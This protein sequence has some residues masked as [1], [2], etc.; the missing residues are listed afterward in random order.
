MTTKHTIDRL[1]HRGD[2][3]ASGPVYVPGA[4][5]DEEVTGE[6]DGD[7]LGDVKIIT[8]SP[9]RVAAPCSHYKSCGGC[10]LQHAADGFLANWKSDAVLDALSAYGLSAPTR[11]ISTS[12]PRSRRRAMFSGRRTK[13]G[14]LVGLHGRASSTIIEIPNCQLLRGELV[15][16]IPALQE[17]TI[18]GASRKGELSLA[19]TQ[20]SV[21]VDVVVTGGKSL[22][23][24]AFQIRLAAIASQYDLARLT[25]G[26]ELVVER[27]APAQIFGHAQVVPPAGAFLQATRQG[28]DALIASVQRAVGPAK[29]VADL[30]AGCGTFSLPLSKHAEV[31]AVEEDAEMLR[32]LDAGWRHADGLKKISTEARDLFR[33]P[34]LLEEL[35]PFDAIVID[36]PR[37]GAEN[38]TVELAKGQAIIASVSCNPQT[39]ARDA[40]ILCNAGYTIDWIDVID[41]FRWSPHVELVARMSK[42]N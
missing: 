3:V 21:G 15:A 22:D 16:A 20:S 36:P 37:A 8:P 7:R 38:Q 1:G 14:A 11:Q 9:N 31:R 27:R 5:P 13:K 32:A 33:R 35:K 2:G 41:Q 19:V 4:L 24:G 12:P 26:V 29:H 25:W 18:A 23:D 34:L 17:L 28:Q 10:S 6:L 40:N 30:F 39:F 42:K